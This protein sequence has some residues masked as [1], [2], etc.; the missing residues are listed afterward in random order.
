MARRCLLLLVLLLCMLAARPI[1]AR[2]LEEASASSRDATGNTSADNP[3]QARPPISWIDSLPPT[4]LDG[5]P[6]HGWSL[7]G[8]FDDPQGL[9]SAAPTTAPGISSADSTSTRPIGGNPAATNV[10]IGTGTLGKLLRLDELGIR[11]G[12]ILFYDQTYNALGGIKPGGWAGQELLLTEMAVDLEK[13]VGWSGGRLAADL[14]QHNGTAAGSLTGDVMVFEG[15][16]GGPPL[17]RVEL[18]Q[19]WFLQTLFD[20]RLAIRLGKLVPTFQFANLEG[21]TSLIATSIFTMPTM[22]GRLPGYPDSACGVTV[23]ALPTEHVYSYLG[24]YDGRLGGS[25]E[26]TGMLGPQFNGQYFYIGEV[27][28]RYS[29][30]GSRRLEGKAGYGAWYQSGW[31]PRFDGTLQR[32]MAGWYCLATQQLWKETHG[33]ETEVL[34]AFFQ[35]GRSDPNVQQVPM[36]L[37]GG[38]TWYGFL[39]CRPRD[40]IG[41][42]VFWGDLTRAPGAGNLPANETTFQCYYQ[43]VLARNM[44]VQPVVTYIRDPGSNANLASPLALTLRVGLVF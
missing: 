4:H 6:S 16:D 18:Y 43:G 7:F 37:S 38:L 21:A 5:S 32:G 20:N 10:E 22:L 2:P 41:A 40:S 29:L 15:L 9:T 42:G 34:T 13:L 19:L 11:L 8:G 24:F 35:V 12:G 31:L 39:R 1:H 44:F 30:G 28:A 17:P 33:E 36:F 26:P 3:P 23:Q 27:G 14:L 25:G